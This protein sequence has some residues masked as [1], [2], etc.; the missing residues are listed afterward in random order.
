MVTVWRG[1]GA[2]LLCALLLKAGLWL[3]G[4][5][6]EAKVPWP[7]RGT[8]VRIQIRGFLAPLYWI[9]VENARG[10]T[11]RQLWLDWGP[12]DEANLYRTPAGSVAVIG[13]GSVVA[14]IGLPPDGP[15]REE[16][17]DPAEA[18]EWVYL[19]RMAWV[20]R[21]M[22]LRF[23]AAAAHAECIPLYGEGRIPVR[24]R[25]QG[26]GSWCEPDEGERASP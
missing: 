9:V 10:R 16:M 14:V 2:L 17:V 24:T 25:Y 11:S 1:T 7:D 20:G 13:A 6:A 8:E 4:P 3:I 15:P 5:N 12:A 21:E 26:R 23:F 18:D 22:A 19:G